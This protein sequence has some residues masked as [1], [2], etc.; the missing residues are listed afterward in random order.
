MSQASPSEQAWELPQMLTFLSVRG[1]PDFLYYA[2]PFQGQWFPVTAS[3]HWELELHL[4]ATAQA[5]ADSQKL[6]A[7]IQSLHHM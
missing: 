1:D 4:I 7:L 5:G 3:A 2:N 6:P